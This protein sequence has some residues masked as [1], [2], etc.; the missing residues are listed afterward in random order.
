MLMSKEQKI[1]LF[2]K[3]S[4]GLRHNSF[5]FASQRAAFQSGG[6]KPGESFSKQEVNLHESEPTYLKV[7]V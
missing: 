7:C 4:D 3:C 2:G 1:K 5:E 6:N